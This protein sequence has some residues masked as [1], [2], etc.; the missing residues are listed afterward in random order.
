M[1]IRVKR[2][3]KEKG[4][5]IGEL[6]IDGKFECYTLEDEVRKEK[7]YGETAIPQGIYRMSLR[8]EG[9]KNELYVKKF[10]TQIH[11]GMLWIRDIPGFEYVYIHIGNITADTLGCI[12]V[13]KTKNEKT[14][15][16]GE[17]T[18]AYLQMYKKVTKAID[19]REDVHIIIEEE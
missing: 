5:T 19:A 8:K 10:G 18:A 11:K 3:K 14:G 1:E 16:I 7:K 17:S 15:T 2:T 9:G 4:Y 12:L 6:Y 13:G